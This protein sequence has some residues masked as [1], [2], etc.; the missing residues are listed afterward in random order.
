MSLQ[1]EEVSIRFN[2]SDNPWIA[3]HE[4]I[5]FNR[6]KILKIASSIAAACEN[7]EHYKNSYQ[8]DVD[9]ERAIK[10]FVVG[11]ENKRPL[12]MALSKVLSERIALDSSYDDWFNS[13]VAAKRCLESRIAYGTPG[14]TEA[15]RYQALYS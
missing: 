12:Y 9:V 5:T 4:T 10:E 15:K 7:K 2:V 14:F 1:E 3:K 8:Y 13:Y 11:V 6:D